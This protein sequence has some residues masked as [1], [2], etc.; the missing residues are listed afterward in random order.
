[1]DELFRGPQ[2][3]ALPTACSI[4][5]LMAL[6]FRSKSGATLTTAGVNGK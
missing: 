1:M 4:L 6:D 2:N 3:Y 5:S